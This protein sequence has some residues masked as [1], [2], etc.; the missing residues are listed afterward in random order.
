MPDGAPLLVVGRPTEAM[1]GRMAGHFAVETLDDKPEGWLAENGAR[2]Q[3]ATMLGHTAIDAAFLD[4]VPNLKLFAN[5]GVGYDTIDAAE[6]ARR[7]VIVTHTPDVLNAEVATTALMLMMACYRDL[8]R[9]DAYVRAGRWET[10]GNAPLTRSVDNQK[11]GILGMGRIG[12][13]IA[14]KLAP[15]NAEISYH[16]RSPKDLPYRYCDKLVDMARD[17]DT[18][19]VITPGGAST[20]HLVNAE[21]MEALGPNG[22]LVNVARGT[23]VDEAALIEA[24]STGTLGSAGL[25]VFEAEPHV[26]QALRDLPNTVLLPHVGSGTVETRQAMG[27]LVVDNLIDHLTKGSVRTPVPECAGLKQIA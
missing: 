10:E 21:V 2:F 20:H 15:W 7:G 8:L 5:Y 27:D 9:D 12:Q 11:V 25:D 1:L 22:C 17:V 26:P 23:V 24:L 4:A 3:H 14:A 6:C 13:A 19:I 18:L 16:T